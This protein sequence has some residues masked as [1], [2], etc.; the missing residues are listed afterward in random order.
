MIVKSV[1][2]ATVADWDNVAN[3]TFSGPQLHDRG[4][5]VHKQ[6]DMS[7][8]IY[9]YMRA[10]HAIDLIRSQ[11]LHLAAIS[12][13]TDP[14]EAWWHDHL[15]R[16]HG[17]LDGVRAFGS[18]WTSRRLDEPF[19]RLY[20]SRCTHDLPPDDPPVRVAS[21][22]GRIA[23]S[24]I[25]AMPVTKAKIFIAPVRYTR[26]KQ[27]KEYM[28]SLRIEPAEIAREAAHA[29]FFKRRHFALEREF[30]I[31]YIERVYDVSRSPVNAEHL[32]WHEQFGWSHRH[33]LE[34]NLDLVVRRIPVDADRLVTDVMIGPVRKEC[35]ANANS[36]KQRL[37]Q[38]GYQK[39]RRSLIY[40][41]LD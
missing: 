19:W 31:V 7:R 1:P 16:P 3:H 17:P 38:A 32:V 20:E 41:A 39:V 11:S 33:E 37:K 23:A 21:T 6:L 12:N 30:R 10:A 5:F 8:P 29:L 28:R 40:Q 15:F 27:L 24:L 14:Y 22:I 2:R 9:R 35:E 34:K 36:L 25:S 13:W 18:C 26:E 4:V